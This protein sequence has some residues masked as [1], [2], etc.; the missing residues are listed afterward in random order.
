MGVILENPKVNDVFVLTDS[1]G[2][3]STFTVIDYTYPVIKAQDD[4]GETWFW[5]NADST[6]DLIKMLDEINAKGLNKLPADF[7]ASLNDLKS[8]GDQ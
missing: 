7:L 6:D 3:Q 4:K 2:A 5:H 8:Q 1:K